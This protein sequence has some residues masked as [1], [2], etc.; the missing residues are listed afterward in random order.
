MFS[1]AQAIL[2][3]ALQGI[4]EL[5]PIS[6][7]GH[8]VILE[9]FLNWQMK[10]SNPMFLTF[11]VATHTA[12]AL[13]LFLFFWKDWWR[14]IK[15]LLRSLKEREIKDSDAKLGWLL[16]VG[17][18]PAGI[19][20]LLFEETFKKIFASAQ[21]AAGFLVLN[22]VMLYG[23]EILRRRAVA[24]TTGD[25][26]KRI[27]KLSWGQSLKVGGLQCLALLPGFSRTGSTITGGLLTGLSHEDAARFSFLLATPVIG[28]A[29]LLK[30]PELA[31]PNG[32][33]ILGPT[34]AG[35][36]AAAV[37]AFFSV[38]FLEK[39]FKNDTLKPFAIYCL[40]AGIVTSVILLLG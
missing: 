2:I 29:S 22:G 27:A 39:Y 16:V 14:I 30:I 40:A 5:F 9:R 18:I 11:L 3:G 36:L 8:S 26:D 31:T 4:T 17:T 19:M 33:A 1:Y 21:L 24:Q 23:A 37:A 32:Q 12:T 6:S 38:R 25:S 35:A 7:L 28:A 13:V 20:G 15:G 10:E 34:V